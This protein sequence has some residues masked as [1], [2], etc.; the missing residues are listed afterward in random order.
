MRAAAVLGPGTDDAPVGPEGGTAARIR[1]KVE[2]L[3]EASG[4]FRMLYFRD[5][6]GY[7]MALSAPA[8]WPSA[9][10]A[11]VCSDRAMAGQCQSGPC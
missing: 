2:V 7:A 5:P 8:V 9:P 11:A 10:S 4:G 3:K 6:N 1:D